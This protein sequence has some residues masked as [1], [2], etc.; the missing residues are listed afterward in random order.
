VDLALP[1]AGGLP[2]LAQV[3][4]RSPKTRVL[5]VDARLDEGRML[6][7]AKAGAHGYMLEEAIPAYLV[8]AIRVMAA[9]EVWLSRKLMAKV[10]VELQRLDRLQKEAGGR[11]KSIKATP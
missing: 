2:V 5:A 10:V 1:P 3:R 6:S 8:K 9:G 4:R 11:R 7:V